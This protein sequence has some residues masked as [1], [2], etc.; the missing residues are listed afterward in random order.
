MDLSFLL[1]WMLCVGI[2]FRSFFLKRG[3]EGVLLVLFLLSWW[4][5]SPFIYSVALYVCRSK[6][7]KRLLP[8][9]YFSCLLYRITTI[10]AGAVEYEQ[11][12]TTR[13][14]EEAPSSPPLTFCSN[15][16]DRRILGFDVMKDDTKNDVALRKKYQY[17]PQSCTKYQTRTSLLKTGLCVKCSYHSSR[18]IVLNQ[19]VLSTSKTRSQLRWALN[20][21]PHCLLAKEERSALVYLVLLVS[22]HGNAR[23]NNNCIGTHVIF[24]SPCQKTVDLLHIYTHILHMPFDSVYVTSSLMV[25]HIMFYLSSGGRGTYSTIP[26]LFIYIHFYNRERFQ[27]RQV[28]LKRIAPKPPFPSSSSGTFLRSRHR[29]QNRIVIIGWAAPTLPEEAATATNRRR[30]RNRETRRRIRRSL[31]TLTLAINRPIPLS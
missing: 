31:W 22:M 20:S 30:R 15:D 12:E 13:Q 19:L 5:S 27:T 16:V 10:P 1:G 29:H 28:S 3:R 11:E 17:Y 7:Q 21:Y 25:Q 8:S 4:S 18:K 24:L 6:K 14:K 23:A 2:L 9:T 26:Y